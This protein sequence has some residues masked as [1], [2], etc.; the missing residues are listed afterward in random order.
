M[1]GSGVLLAREGAPSSIPATAYGQ[2]HPRIVASEDNG[3][4]AFTAF[5][6]EPVFDPGDNTALFTGILGGGQPQMVVREGDVAAGTGGATISGFFGEAV[7]SAGAIVLRANLAGA[8]ITAANNEGLWTNSPDT[9]AAPV[10]VAREGD[11]APCLP[12]TLAAFERFSA[13]TLA[14]DGSVCFHAYLKD[15]TAVPAV[16]SGNDGSLWR[17]RGGRLYLIAREGDIANNTTGDILRSIGSFACGGAGGVVY[18]VSFIPGIG[19]T[20]SSTQLGVYLDRGAADP[21]P[22][23]VLRRGDTFDVDGTSRSVAGIRLST[24]VNVGGGTG[25]YGRT[26]NDNGDVLLNLT[27]SGNTSGLFVLGAPPVE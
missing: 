12:D 7:N 6:L 21:A 22:L 11:V 26:L 9:G 5:L 8:G 15:A 17:W 1:R 16:H 10:L 18:D 2:I 25:G 24:E 27:L 19:N 3:R 4:Y 23:L 13:F 20:T 14:D